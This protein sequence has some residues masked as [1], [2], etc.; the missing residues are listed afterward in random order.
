MTTLTLFIRLIH[1]AIVAFV[2]L[3]PFLSDSPA[4]D[5]LH[6]TF[7]V[8][9]MFHWAMNS[10]VCALS[11]LESY[12]RKM[13]LEHSFVHQIIAPIYDLNRSQ[14]SAMIWTS[15]LGLCAASLKN[16]IRLK[17]RLGLA[18]GLKLRHL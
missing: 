11:A 12:L 7:T 15:T 5:I 18:T 16:L 6:V 14:E 2:V 17:S 1:L 3:T 8:G 4:L 10:N 9:L 13:P